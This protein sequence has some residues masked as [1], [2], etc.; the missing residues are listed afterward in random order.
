MSIEDTM[1]L[2]MKLNATNV[3]CTKLE[4]PPGGPQRALTSSHSVCALGARR[5]ISIARMP[6]SRIWIVAPLAYLPLEFER[7]YLIIY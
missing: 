7:S 5:L 3:M 2:H 6:K 4:P 1:M